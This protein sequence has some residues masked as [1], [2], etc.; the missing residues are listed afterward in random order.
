MQPTFK[1][2]D[3][4]LALQAFRK[5]PKLGIRLDDIVF[6]VSGR[7]A[8]LVVPLPLLSSRV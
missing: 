1:E 6:G 5:D 3:M 4:V 8:S 7:P 2:S